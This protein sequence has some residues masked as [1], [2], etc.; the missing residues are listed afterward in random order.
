MLPDALP[1]RMPFQKGPPFVRSILLGKCIL[2]SIVCFRCCSR[3]TAGLQECCVVS[4]GCAASISFLQQTRHSTTK[5][6]INVLMLVAVVTDTW[7]LS[8]RAL[9]Q[10]KITAKRRKKS[11]QTS[12]VLFYP[13]C[14]SPAGLNESLLCLRHHIKLISMSVRVV[15]P[16]ALCSRAIVP[17]FYTRSRHW[18]NSVIVM[19]ALEGHTRRTGPAHTRKYHPLSEIVERRK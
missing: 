9:R 2:H 6:S 10:L 11:S 5:V 1:A 7:S 3:Q 17:P 13:L 4:T 18:N 12:T 15:H 19:D 16:A 8:P 14:C